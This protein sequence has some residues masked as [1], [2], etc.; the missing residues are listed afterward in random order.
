[1]KIEFANGS[2]IESL[3][4]VGETT[5][6]V[7]FYSGYTP[8]ILSMQGNC[9]DKDGNFYPTEILYEAWKDYIGKEIDCYDGEKRIVSDVDMQGD[10]IY[11]T[12]EV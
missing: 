6:G 1:M 4:N 3:D 2:V 9:T 12:I 5:R 7:G 11:I 8:I 10:F